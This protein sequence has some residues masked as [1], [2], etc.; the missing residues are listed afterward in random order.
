MFNGQCSIFLDVFPSLTDNVLVV[1]YLLVWVVTFIWYHRRFRNIDAGSMIIGSYMA[2]AVFSIV[3]LNDETFNHE[4]DPLA[5][6][7]FLYLY[8]MLMIALAPAIYHHCSGAEKIEDPH[9]KSLYIPCIILIVSSVFMLMNAYSAPDGSI[10]QLLTDA[11]AGKNA[12]LE[13]IAEKEDS[14]GGIRNLPSVLFNL[15]FDCSTFLFFYFSTQ[16]HKNRIFLLALFFALFAGMAV[17]IMNGQ[18]GSVIKACLTIIVGYSLFRRYLSERFNRMAKLAGITMAVI[19]AVPIV[20]ITISRFSD[21]KGS[22][23]VSGY[24]YW[25]IGQANLYFNNSAMDPGGIRYG[26]RTFNMVKRAIWSDTPKNYMERRDKYCNLKIDDYYF[27]T[28]VGDFVIDFGPILAFLLFVVFNLWVLSEIKPRDGTIKLHQLLLLYFTLCVCMQGGMVLF[29]Y[30]D[31]SNL[32][33]FVF[34]VLYVWLRYHE[35][36]LKRFPLIQ[37]D[38]A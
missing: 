28:F 27:V 23:T 17:P 24:V 7:P 6:F 4:Y 3:T 5:F 29:S 34:I 22:K 9:S 14:G 32:I 10:T 15:F 38:I 18:R 21:R 1:G 16:Q 13:Q 20:A 19:I 37:K 36:L 30:S 31:T 8:I 2:Y 35:A 12:Y 11:D 25:Y 26:D 33:V